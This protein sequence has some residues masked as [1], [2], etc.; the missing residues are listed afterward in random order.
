MQLFVFPLAN[1]VFFPATSK[2]LNVFEPR[3]L[4]MVEDSLRTGTPIA[5]GFVDQP[6]ASHTVEVGEV[7]SFVRPV[8]G[9]GNPTVVERRP[10]G[11][12]LIFLQALGKVRLGSLTQSGQPYLVVEAEIIPETTTL[13]SSHMGQLP[14][15]QKLLASWVHKNIPEPEVRDQFLNQL[16]S[17]DEIISSCASFLLHDPDLQ[18]AVLEEDTLDGK[19]NLLSGLLATG[20]IS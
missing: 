15:L 2:P 13:S 5:L 7:L 12:L 17:P 14:I 11:T 8:A 4:Q 9:Y 1:M 19:I 18:Q 3:Y 10:D 20:K 16:K 6:H